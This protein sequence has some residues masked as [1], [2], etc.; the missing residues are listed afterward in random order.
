MRKFCVII[1]VCVCKVFLTSDFAKINILT[2]K[3]KFFSIISY[4]TILHK[5]LLKFYIPLKVSFIFI[6]PLIKF[7][8]LAKIKFKKLYDSRAENPTKHI[9][10]GSSFIIIYCSINYSM[11]FI[12]LSSITKTSF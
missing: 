1:C 4:I 5:Y 12:C 3:Q 8:D 10:P 2:G 6:I 7:K 9:L 11:A